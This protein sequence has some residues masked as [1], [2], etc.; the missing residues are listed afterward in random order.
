MHEVI[1]NGRPKPVAATYDELSRTQLLRLVPMLFGAYTD[2]HRQRI[3]L[4]TVL[5]GVSLPLVLRFTPV[6]LLEIFW[7][8]DFLLA[9]ELVFTRQ[10]LPV[11]RAAWYRRRLHGP[12]DGLAGVQFLEF[13]FADS[14]FMAYAQGQEETWLD[15]LVATLYRPQRRPYRPHA[16]DYAGDRRQDFNPALIDARVPEV[17]R[18]PQAEK[19]AI[20]LWYRGCRRALELRYPRVFTPA[21]EQQA[22]APGGWDYVLREM[23]GAAFGSFEETGRQKTGQLLAKMEDDARRAEELKRQAEMQKNS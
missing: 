1:L 15:H 19:L 2:R 11:V 23:S 18:L 8:T 3:E 7:L 14:Y 21:N 6:Q 5:L 20:Y 10:L 13:V 9:E 22:Q 12:A 16:A 4:L 17:A